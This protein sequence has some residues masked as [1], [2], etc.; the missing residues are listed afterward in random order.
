MKKIN[1]VVIF[2]L[3]I[4]FIT[5]FTAIDAFADSPTFQRTE[6]QLLTTYPVVIAH[7]DYKIYSFGYYTLYKDDFSSIVYEDEGAYYIDYVFPDHT[8]YYDNGT[9][10]ADIYDRYD[11]SVMV[12]P[13]TKVLWANIGYPYVNMTPGESRGIATGT[14]RL[15]TPYGHTLTLVETDIDF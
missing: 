14:V 9:K 5:V 2:I 8:Q 1:K 12:P 3:I 10:K 13:G 7:N 15:S 4:S 6:Q 11:Y